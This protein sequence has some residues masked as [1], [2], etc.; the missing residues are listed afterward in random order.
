MARD[1]L[2]VDFYHQW[3]NTYKEGAVRDVTLK[4][5]RLAESWLRKNVASLKLKD[6]NRVKYQSILNAYAEDHEHQTVM[7][8][9]HLLKAAILDAVDERLLDRD[10]TRKAVIKGCSPREKKTKYLN[11]FELHSLLG[12]L[13]LEGKPCDNWDWLIL[14]IA[15]TGLRFAEALG[16]TPADIDLARQCVDVNKTWSYKD[17]GGFAPTK[18][19]SSNRKVTIDWT[20]A[21]QFAT[22]ISQMPQDKPIFIPYIDG[23]PKEVYNSTANGILARHCKNTG[24]PVISIHGLRHTHASIML[25]AGAS[26]ASV[27]RRL[28]HSSISTTQK[29]YLHVIQEM[30]NQDIDLMM[31]ALSAL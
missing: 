9:H 28:G 7:D 17:G 11:Q 14:L 15:K 19:K 16:I 21:T 22:A 27:S 10:P 12:D 2:L 13:K 31:R 5:Y 3:V 1:T 24:V 25:Y 8:F 30:E 6:I 23:E 26:V 4:K 20:I 18:N 29:V